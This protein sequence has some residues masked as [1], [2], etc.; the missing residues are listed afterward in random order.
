M[1]VDAALQQLTLGGGSKATNAKEVVESF[2]RAAK[3]RQI[4]LS[5]LEGNPFVYV[6]P[7]AP[8]PEPV[9]K[10]EPDKEEAP[11]DPQA[12]QRA[13]AIRAV[14]DLELQSVLL[15][16]RTRSAMISNNLLAE[17]QTIKGWT[18]S[19]I[20]SRRVILTWREETY[21]LQMAR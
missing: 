13:E 19:R 14:Q 3:D 10:E 6:P 11:E 7:K 1:R 4:P 5:D 16:G 18:V 8:A 20:E 2:Y 12:D 15:G 9:K 17:G 21:V